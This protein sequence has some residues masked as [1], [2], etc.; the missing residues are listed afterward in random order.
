MRTI[1]FTLLLGLMVVLASAGA[2]HATGNGI[3]SIDH[4]DG[5]LGADT[6]MANGDLR[7][8]LR[9]DN[10]GTNG[11]GVKTDVSNGFRVFSPDGAVF[12]SVRMDSCGPFASLGDQWKFSILFNV[13]ANLGQ[14][15]QH[16]ASGPDTVGLLCSGNPTNAGKQLPTTYNDTCIAIIVGLTAGTA[17]ANHLKTLCIDSSFFQPG[18]TW[19]WVDK[20][21]VVHYTDFVGIN[22]MVHG[23]NGYCFVLRDTNATAV[24]DRGNGLPKSFSVSQNYPNP[25]NPTTKIDFDVPSKS[26]VKLTIYNVLGQRVTTL[27]DKSMNAGKYQASWDGR[28][29][30]GTQ[31]SS[32]IYFYKFEAGSFVQTKKMIMLK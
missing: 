19:S 13:V 4:I 30:S 22:S 28:S 31:V 21:L 17:S 7:I 18:G 16:V 29:D 2:A 24:N 6:L 27:I 32:G 25:F 11:V 14:P 3:I 5:L 10:T 12:D 23:A 9:F 26:Q 20:N 1:K 15:N 8:V